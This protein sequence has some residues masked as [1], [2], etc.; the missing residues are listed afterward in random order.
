MKT[1]Y[2][3]C[4][5]AFITI[6]TS[7]KNNNEQELVVAPI[8]TEPAPMETTTKECYQAIIE[9]DTITLTVDVNSIN[10]FTGELNYS[11]EQKDKN[12][13]TLLGNVRGDTII[14]DYTFQ[15]EGKTSVKEVVF[16]KKDANTI[17]EGYG[18]TVDMNGKVAFKDKSNLKF[19]GNVVYNKIACKE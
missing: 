19:D 6:L 11:Y 13:G 8:A 15:S 18:H 17:L 3:F 14:A 12:F 9:K 1:L 10:E 7:C 16:L 5:V 4:S 2:L